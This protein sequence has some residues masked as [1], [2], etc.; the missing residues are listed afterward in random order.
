MCV[1]NLGTMKGVLCKICKYYNTEL[2]GSV[3]YL[4]AFIPFKAK[5]IVFSLFS[6]SQQNDTVEKRKKNRSSPGGICNYNQRRPW[7]EHIVSL[8]MR[9]C[10]QIQTR[11]SVHKTA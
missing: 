2:K 8:C 1:Y 6:R 10:L 11:Q 5:L 3:Y 7:C 4:C 9:V